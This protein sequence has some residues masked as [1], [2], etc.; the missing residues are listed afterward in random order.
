MLVSYI[1]NC[2]LG[3]LVVAVLAIPTISASSASTIETKN[4]TS[5]NANND[6]H[7]SI[8]DL[9]GA[10]E[11]KRNLF[12]LRSSVAAAAATRKSTSVN[13]ATTSATSAKSWFSLNDSPFYKRE[14]EIAK[15]LNKLLK[16]TRDQKALGVLKLTIGIEKK[17]R[18]SLCRNN[19]GKLAC[20]LGI[21]ATPFGI[22][23]KSAINYLRQDPTEEILQRLRRRVG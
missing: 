6:E 13:K 16:L 19:F 4:P 21:S 3:L 15:M 5:N 9:E 18:Q 20:D 8:V 22:L 10:V 17:W 11:K 2:S 7:S 1:T 23:N 12:L 14:G